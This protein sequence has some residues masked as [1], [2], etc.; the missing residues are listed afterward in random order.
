MVAD[1]G[2]LQALGGPFHY[3]YAITF[4]EV[5]VTYIRGEEHGQMFEE[6]FTCRELAKFAKRINK[7]YPGKAQLIDVA[8]H[9]KDMVFAEGV[10]EERRAKITKTMQKWNIDMILEES[11]KKI[12]KV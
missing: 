7:K 12:K 6:G 5:S 8:Q 4:G 3:R 1:I 9:I 10:S 2:R 11:N